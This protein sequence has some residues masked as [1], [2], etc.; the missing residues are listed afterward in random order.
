MSI[1]KSFLARVLTEGDTS[2]DDLA[3]VKKRISDVKKSAGGEMFNITDVIVDIGSL[4]GIPTRALKS[5]IQELKTGIRAAADRIK[6]APAES[7]NLTTLH[8]ELLAAN[9]EASSKAGIKTEAKADSGFHGKVVSV[10]KNLGFSDSILNDEAVEAKIKAKIS[11]LGAASGVKRAVNRLAMLI[12][13]EAI[14]PGVVNTNVKDFGPQQSVNDAVALM[15][16]LGVDLS[17]KTVVKTKN[18]QQVIQRNIHNAISSNARLKQ[19]IN[20]FLKAAKVK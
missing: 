3:S 20:I 6:M 7:T 10:L 12:T 15:K 1:G 5:N 14:E 8:Q 2:I 19:A 17:D 11:E 4:F 16:I 13:N 18:Q 9:T